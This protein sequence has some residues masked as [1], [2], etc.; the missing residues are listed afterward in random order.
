L[1]QWSGAKKIEFAINMFIE[2]DQAWVLKA[3]TRPGAENITTIV[4]AGEYLSTHVPEDGP[5][6]DG[7]AV[8]ALRR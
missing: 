4:V 2:K 3:L 6:R 5:V 7:G 1:E 8:H